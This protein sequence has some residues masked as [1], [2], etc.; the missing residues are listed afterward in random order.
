V[1]RHADPPIA[2][3][4]ALIVGLAIGL[5]N[6]IL[7]AGIGINPFI[8]TVG[9]GFVLSGIALV[10]TGNIDYVVD[11]P[12]FGTLGAGRWHG[13]PYSGMILVLCLFIGGL[14]LARTVYGSR[15]MLSAET[16]RRVSCRA[17]E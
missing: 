2:F 10:V 8:T 12:D 1:G 13:F 5:A 14:A 7:V 17:Y 11:N 6:G 4:A 15:S 16:L 9:T 3:L